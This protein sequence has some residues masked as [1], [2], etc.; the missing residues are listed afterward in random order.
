MIMASYKSIWSLLSVLKRAFV[1]ID[2]SVITIKRS[3]GGQPNQQ[4]QPYES[5]FRKRIELVD[6]I[7]WICAF[8]LFFV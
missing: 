6:E 1:Y 5:V 4:Y 3:L 2:C 7:F 8:A